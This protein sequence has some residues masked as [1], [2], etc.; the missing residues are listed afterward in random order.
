MTSQGVRRIP[1]QSGV[2]F[3]LNAGDVLRIIDPMGEQ[4]SDL[5]AFSRKAP[6]SW[7][8]SGKSIDFAGRIYLTTGDTLY[9]NMSEPMLT[10]A[11]DTVGR[12]DFLLAPCSQETF[13]LLYEGDQSNHPSCLGNLANALAAYD[14]PVQGIPNAFNVFMNVQVRSDGRVD[15][16]PPLS[17]PGDRLEL[18]AEQD[19]IIGM[20][21]CSAEMTNNYRLKPIDFEI[22]PR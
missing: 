18:R 2:A 7:I 13:D 11:H 3:E 14:I 22:L 6:R 20:T 12:H 8:S 10:I 15:I 1:V 9:S 21:A 19:L 16:K 17:K 4:V 5:V